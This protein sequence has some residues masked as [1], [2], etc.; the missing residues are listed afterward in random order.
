MARQ[1]GH[2]D[3]KPVPGLVARPPSSLVPIRKRPDFQ[4]LDDLAPYEGELG[5]RLS[6]E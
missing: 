3:Q 6:V 2:P 4:N 5:C 1:V